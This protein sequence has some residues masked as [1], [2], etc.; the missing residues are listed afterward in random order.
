MEQYA[1]S[2]FDYEVATENAIQNQRGFETT[3]HMLGEIL[4]SSLR[5]TYLAIVR[6]EILARDGS[7]E[8]SWGIRKLSG[9]LKEMEIARQLKEIKQ[10]TG[11]ENPKPEDLNKKSFVSLCGGAEQYNE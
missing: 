4:Y 2:L 5:K 8:P 1:H 3:T 10:K 6:E 11:N 7:F 9:E